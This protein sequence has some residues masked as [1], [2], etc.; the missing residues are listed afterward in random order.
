ML[1]QNS[2]LKLNYTYQEICKIVGSSD[3]D[4]Q[5][6]IEEIAYDS[7]K[8]TDGAHVLFCALSGEFRDGHSFIQD[9]YE[10][11]V[12]H[13]MV[14]QHVN[15]GLFENSNFILVNNVLEAI[16]KIA[17]HHRSQFSGSVVAITG[18]NGKTIVKEWLST[19]L[20]GQFRV[21][22][23]PKSYNSQLGVALSLLEINKNTDIAIIEAGISQPGEMR[24][25]Q[26]MIHPT[27]GILTHI[28]SAHLENFENIDELIQEKLILFQGVQTVFAPES[29]SYIS[30][31]N[32]I[33]R[34]NYSQVLNALKFEGSQMT[35]NALLAV[36][37]ATELGSDLSK[38]LSSLPSL[39]QLSMRLESFAGNNNNIIINDTY[40]LD[41]DSLRLSLE[42]QLTRSEGRD[43]VV[44]VG[45]NE[46]ETAKKSEI[47]SLVQDFG[48]IQ[49]LFYSP[50]NPIELNYSNTCLLLKGNRSL[51][52]ES[53]VKKLRQK[54]HQT[55]LEIDLRAVRHNISIFKS[56]INHDTK[57][58]CMVKASSYGSDAKTMGMFLQNS[59]V[60]YLGVAYVD[61]GIELR[62]A[63]VSLPILVMN[64]EEH[65]FDACIEYNL[66][67]VFFSLSQLDRFVGRLID[68]G[69]DRYPIHIK[70]ETGMN[71][72][73]FVQSE[74]HEL[75]DYIKGQPEIYIQSIYSHLA[76]SDNIHSAF[77]AA[78]I[79][80]FSIMCD[81]FDNEF[82]QPYIKHL[83]NSSGIT[84]YPEAQFDM[85]RLGIGMY[86]VTNDAHL[87]PAIQWI[88]SISQ[89]KKV[90]KGESVGYNRSYIA[91][92][93]MQIAIIPVGYADGF[94]RS[95]SNGVGRVFIEGKPCPIIG[96]VCMDMIMVDIGQLEVSAG[97]KVE[98]IGIN[99]SMETL[100][101]MMD[102][103][104]YEVMT[105]F[106]TRL[107]RI[108]IEN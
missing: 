34:E 16:Q 51:R 83:L 56:R 5:G 29:L 17:A 87:Q 62:Q 59:G 99:Q 85:V 75:I 12:R 26:E 4:D 14:E 48:P 67:P 61:E 54:H 71:R 65:S 47:E 64:S 74:I 15:T 63:G 38:I 36:A 68:H 7:R 92:E 57:I 108:Y 6:V 49:L 22:R 33:H 9:A 37:M 69:V 2:T 20:S 45:L 80:R 89:V 35:D 23:S 107:H 86:G 19:L 25:L 50:N 73:G 28:G 95:L 21:A 55:Y 84:N 58:L 105:N 41:M 40:S 1:Q 104:P 53:L 102:T 94:R 18:S 32:T 10:K 97:T 82:K 81:Q 11:G 91:P 30:S 24:I 60:N 90:N 13:F 106:S 98:L 3:Q 72:L 31:V 76:E 39:Q 46:N 66:E 77:T 101:K 78:Q 88:S 8:I 52:M 100:A 27:H 103:I 44:I 70:L 93:D 96:N 42:H 79:E 43:R